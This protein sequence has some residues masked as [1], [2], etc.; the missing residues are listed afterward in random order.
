MVDRYSG[1]STYDCMATLGQQDTWNSITVQ[2][3]NGFF[4]DRH[5]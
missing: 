5:W 4:V 2:C 3:K 1:F